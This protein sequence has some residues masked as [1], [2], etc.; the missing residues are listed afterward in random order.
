MHA[1]MIMQQIRNHAVIM[2]NQ[3]GYIIVLK[4]LAGGGGGG[5]GGGVGQALLWP[6]ANPVFCVSRLSRWNTH[7]YSYT[8]QHMD[9]HVSLH[10]PG[11]A[12]WTE[13]RLAPG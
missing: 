10:V 4:L 11:E 5:G 2:P 7:G 3:E 12:V 6:G 13:P 8:C 9:M 1:K